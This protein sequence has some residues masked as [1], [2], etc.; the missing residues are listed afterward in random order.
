VDVVV[1]AVNVSKKF[2]FVTVLR[3]ITFTVGEGEHTLILGPNGSGKTTLIK[4]VAGL[5]KPSSGLIEVL[6]QPPWK[7]RGRSRLV[8]AVLDENTLPWWCRGIDFLGYVADIK[9]VPFNEVLELA[10]EFGV[11]GF[12]EKRVF[13][14]SSGMKR[15]IMLLSALIG[16]PKVMLLDEPFTS[17]DEK[18]RLKLLSILQEK[19][20]ETTIIMSTHIYLRG[21][22]DLFKKSMILDQGTIRAYGGVGDVIGQYFK[23]R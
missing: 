7:I 18:S 16:K 3:E 4:I 2:M 17:L 20:R 9:G 1:K 23:F 6:G 10:R 5:V 22:E 21:L 12:W 13:T 19:S 11:T 15:K 8:N 14:Y